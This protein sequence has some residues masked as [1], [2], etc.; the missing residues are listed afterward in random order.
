MRHRVK[1][2][3]LALAADQRKALLRTLL[4]SLLQH[5]E[6][7][8]SLGRA[9]ALAPLANKV[10]HLATKGDTVHHIRQ[11]A[12]LVY[13]VYTGEIIEDTKSD[14]LIEETVLRRL[15]RTIAPSFEKAQG[16]YV[17][18]LHLP[19]RRGD[20]APMALVQIVGTEPQAESVVE[21]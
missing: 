2:H 10:I 21:A 5:G 16:G 1:K 12:R 17:R 9:K 14:K 18:V 20:A 6:I 19:P 3:K 11:V 4:T 7:V 15:F 8:T 13:P